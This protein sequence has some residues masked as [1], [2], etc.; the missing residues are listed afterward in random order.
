MECI[1]SPKGREETVGKVFP[2]VVPAFRCSDME[3]LGFVLH[4]VV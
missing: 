1:K 3:V 4:G 2:A